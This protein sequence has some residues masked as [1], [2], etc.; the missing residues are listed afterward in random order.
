V[1]GGHLVVAAAARA[2]AAAI[3]VEPLA[4]RDLQRRRLAAG[5]VQRHRFRALGSIEPRRLTSRPPADA[6]LA[7]R[8]GDV[9]QR[10]KRARGALGLDLVRRLDVGVARA[11]GVHDRPPTPLF[12]VAATRSAKS[13]YVGLMSR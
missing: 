3:D 9:L 7:S 10:A 13:T 11:V 4:A 6:C 2:D 12:S 5:A 8:V 1:R